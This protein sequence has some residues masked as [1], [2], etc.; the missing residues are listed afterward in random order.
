MKVTEK[1]AAQG[2]Q[3]LFVCDFSPLKSSAAAEHVQNASTLNADYICVAYNPG[4]AVRADSAML[5]YTIKKQ[6]KKDVIFNLATRDMNKLA[7]QSHLLGAEML[8]LENVMIIGGDPFTE[9]DLTRQRDVSDF[10]PT[11]LIQAIGEMNQG[12]DFKG[13]KLKT[14]TDI[15]IGASIDLGRGIDREARLTQQKVKAGAQFFLVQPVFDKTEIVSFLDAFESTA[16]SELARVMEQANRLFCSATPANSF[17]TIVAGVVA[18][19]GEVRIANAGHCPALFVRGGSVTASGS[20]GMP[21][22]MFCSSSFS[23]EQL[24]MTA[25]DCLFLFTDGLSERLD[26][27]DREYGVDRIREVLG[28]VDR[29][30]A[31]EVTAAVLRDHEAW[32]AGKN[33]NDD[34]SVMVIRRT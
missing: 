10:R 2:D 14:P 1:C 11:E 21:L 17:A 30:S 22:G 4:K 16:G 32:A 5:A 6:A 8:G 18:A 19:D 20:S 12:L 31:R 25:G 26:R 33:P 28:N 7:M 9:R 3:I 29:S 13:F 27:N 23:V 24:Q 15:C 34:L